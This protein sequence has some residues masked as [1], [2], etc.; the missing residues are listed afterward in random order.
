MKLFDWRLLV[1]SS[2]MMIA[3]L[4]DERKDLVEFSISSVARFSRGLGLLRRRTVWVGVLRLNRSERQRAKEGAQ[5]EGTR[6]HGW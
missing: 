1:V 5:E 6:R 3:A 4:A 2:I